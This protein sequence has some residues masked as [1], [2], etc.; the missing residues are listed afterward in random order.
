MCPT[1]G[2][3]LSSYNNTYI[4]RCIIRIETYLSRY[5]CIRLT[6]SP[7]LQY[8]PTRGLL[9]GKAHLLLIGKYYFAAKSNFLVEDLRDKFSESHLNIVLLAR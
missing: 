3:E 2:R 9:I 5:S 8:C 4:F 1:K 7:M 6:S